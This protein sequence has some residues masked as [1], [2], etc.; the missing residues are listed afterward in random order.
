MQGGLSSRIELFSWFPLR[1]IGSSLPLSV[2]DLLHNVSEWM[3]LALPC[4]AILIFL[5]LL[6]QQHAS[7]SCGFEHFDIVKVG[8]SV[9]EEIASP[10][11]RVDRWLVR[12]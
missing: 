4:R 6:T 9:L 5:C 2:D 1:P 7:R 12:F 11:S 8:V 10:T 3:L